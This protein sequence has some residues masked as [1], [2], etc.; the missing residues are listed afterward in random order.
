[1]SNLLAKELA[2]DLD[3]ARQLPREA[4][5]SPVP[6]ILVLIG[7]LVLCSFRSVSP[8]VYL[9]AHS[10]FDTTARTPSCSQSDEFNFF[11]IFMAVS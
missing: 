5:K 3:R 6:T 11:S 7:Q 1:M 8:S 4:L 2:M 9:Y 10:E